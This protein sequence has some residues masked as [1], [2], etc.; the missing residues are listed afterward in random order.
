MLPAFFCPSLLDVTKCHWLAAVSGHDFAVSCADASKGPLSDLWLESLHSFKTTNSCKHETA[1]PLLALCDSHLKIN[2]ICLLL[3][4][5]QPHGPF[6]LKRS[7]FKTIKLLFKPTFFWLAVLHLPY[8]LLP[9]NLFPLPPAHYRVHGMA[10]GC[11][12]KWLLP[13]LVSWSTTWLSAQRAPSK[14][15]LIQNSFLNTGSLKTDF[16]WGSTNYPSSSVETNQQDFATWSAL[17]QGSEVA[18][19]VFFYSDCVSYVLLSL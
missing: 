18:V 1:V 9:L 10:H 8:L 13:S 17:G 15:K 19:F 3:A 16:W 2:L 11:L 5:V 6:T 7:P 12:L 4:F 14:H